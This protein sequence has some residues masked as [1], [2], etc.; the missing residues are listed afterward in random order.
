MRSK[1]PICLIFLLTTAIST[2]NIFR[3]L[4]NA[5]FSGIIRLKEVRKMKICMKTL[6]K[7]PMALIGAADLS[8][9]SAV[10]AINYLSDRGEK[11]WNKSE[12]ACCQRAVVSS[13]WLRA[14]SS[15]S[16]CFACKV[17]RVW[18]PVRGSG[19]V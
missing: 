17:M 14:A 15:V 7:I 1:L 9:C 18:I 10:R 16:T 13:S 11:V 3:Q 19:A 12:T 5:R 4:S 2:F 6:R 8:V